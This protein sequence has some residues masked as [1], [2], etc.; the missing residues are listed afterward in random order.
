MDDDLKNSATGDISDILAALAASF[1][2]T[3][4]ADMARAGDLSP[5]FQ[6]VDLAYQ[7]VAEVSLGLFL[8]SLNRV[9]PTV[10]HLLVPDTTKWRIVDGQARA[11]AAV[12]GVLAADQRRVLTDVL[13][14]DY[15]VRPSVT[16]THLRNALG[17][18][19]PQYQGVLRYEGIVATPSRREVEAKNPATP[20]QVSEATGAYASKYRDTRAGVL[21]VVAA[22][23]AWGRAQHEGWTQ[24]VENH[25]VD[26]HRILRTWHVTGHNTRDS[27]SSMN[28]QERGVDE[29]FRSGLGNPLMYPGDLTAPAKDVA[30]CNC[31]VTYAIRRQ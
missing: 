12:A 23:E 10:N 13:L 18:T 9:A 6:Y 24:G 25:L 31:W 5:L 7:R 11:R 22:Q 27:H 17:L 4:L 8:T 30:N 19:W 2:L 20:A 14:H 3:Q 16:A 28:D 26:S 29:P 15:D 21:G 1:T